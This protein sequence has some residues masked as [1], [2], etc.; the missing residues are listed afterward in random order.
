MQDCYLKQNSSKLCYNQLHFSCTKKLEIIHV[1]EHDKM[2][3]LI[4]CFIFVYLLKLI[5]LN[6]QYSVLTTGIFF[7][8]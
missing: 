4:T 2:N 7:M 1:N 8:S 3:C 6:V 5:G